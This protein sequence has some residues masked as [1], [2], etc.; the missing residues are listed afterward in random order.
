MKDKNNMRENSSGNLT[1][2]MASHGLVHILFI[3][4]AAIL[5]LIRLEFGLSYTQIG[6][7]TFALSVIAAVA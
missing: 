3:S 1:L 7:F 4:L 6:V 5:P 2:I